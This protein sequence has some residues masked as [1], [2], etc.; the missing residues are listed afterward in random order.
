M[1]STHEGVTLE[2][3]PMTLNQ[4]IDTTGGLPDGVSLEEDPAEPGK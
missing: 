3:V 4:Y 2:V 1:H